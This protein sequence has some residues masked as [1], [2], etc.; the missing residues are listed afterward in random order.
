M[1][2]CPPPCISALQ[3]FWLGRNCSDKYPLI[4]VWPKSVSHSSD[5]IH[6]VSMCSFDW[7]SPEICGHFITSCGTAQIDAERTNLKFSF[8]KILVVV[9]CILDAIHSTMVYSWHVW[10]LS[11]CNH[12]VWLHMCVEWHKRFCLGKCIGHVLWN[13][14]WSLTTTMPNHWSSFSTPSRLLWNVVVPIHFGYLRCIG[15][16]EKPTL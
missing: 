16:I 11:S 15:I 2:V 5:I 13:V 14:A 8:S 6:R 1:V 12:F 9:F 4:L 3:A 10:C 7:C